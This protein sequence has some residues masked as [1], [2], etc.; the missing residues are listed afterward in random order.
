MAYQ[1]K[2]YKKF[3][4]TAATATLVASAVAPAAFAADFTDVTGNYKEAVDFVVSKGVNGTSA[5][6][7]GTSEAIKRVDAA[8][9]LASVL[10]LDIEKAPASG[11]TDVPERAV[12]HVNALKAAGITS[13]KTATTFDANANITR[14]ELAIWIQ[15]GFALKATSTSVAF[16]DVTDRYKEAVAALVDNKVTSGVSETAFGTNA[17]AKRGDFAIFLHRAA[18]T[19]PAKLAI[20]ASATGAK[21]LEVKFNTAV[22]TAK[23]TVTV[24]KGTSNVAISKVTFSEDKKSAVVEL[25]AKLTEGTY[26]VT[27]GDATAE[28]KA[29][30]EKVKTVEL[31][32]DKALTAADGKSVLVGYKVVNQYDENITS[33]NTAY[34]IVPYAT[35]GFAVT[36]DDVDASKGLVTIKKD[37]FKTGDTFNLTLIDNKSTISVSKTLT[38]ADK[39]VVSAVEVTGVYNA[40]GSA[41]N[42]DN[43]AED[44]YLTVVAKDQYG[45]VITDA[46]QL[47]SGLLVNV[48]GSSAA[49]K[50]GNAAA[51]LQNFT[52][53]EDKDKKKHT[54]IALDLKQSGDTVFTLVSLAN[55][56]PVQYKVSV[57][58]GVKLDT[59]SIGAPTGLVAG[60]DTVLLPVS[61]TDNKGNA[62]TDATKV[63]GKITPGGSG[64]SDAKWVTKD[65]ALYIELK[66]NTTTTQSSLVVTLQSQTNKF[67]TEVV[68]VRETAKPKY[69][70]GL[71]SDVATSIY[72]GEKLALEAKHF[73]IQDQYNRDMAST[74]ARFAGTEITAVDGNTG[75][76]SKLTLTGLTVNAGEVKGTETVT[77]GLKDVTG[78]STDV[79]FRVVDRSEFTTYEVA[80]IAT[81][82]AN[83]VQN[84][85]ED[86]A[87]TLKVSG[88]L[89][90]GTKV[91]IPAD[92]YNVVLSSETHVK[93]KDGVLDAKADAV[94][95]KVFEGSVNVVVTI[96]ATGQEI[97]KA[98]T[99]SEAAPSVEKVEF[100]KDSKVTTTL[101]L[102]A[103]TTTFSGASIIDGIVVTDTYGVVNPGLLGANKDQYRLTFTN[104]KEKT[105]T[106][107]DI[108]LNG[109]TGANLADLDSGDTFDATFVVGGKSVKLAVTVK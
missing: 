101:E 41:V 15:K 46:A 68:T 12:K 11:L 76:T 74:D 30:N 92:E 56:T 3:V 1:P 62:V 70:I 55:G 89:A 88:V 14:G 71:K 69:V 53:Y 109:T 13:G 26:T 99:V 87:R 2:S 8:V 43:K 81:I 63:T 100:K 103:G 98:V 85:T 47:E 102:A 97:V 82:Y 44:F 49:V 35:N 7:F 96:N 75:D 59:V 42:E 22:D 21:K 31:L 79:T 6:T 73:V 4:A 23:T 58:S 91:A 29:E 50:D 27:S 105:G 52:T 106:D 77:F 60:G 95:D 48:S 39:S 17:N 5:T 32:S 104:V 51:G 90:D 38:V 40:K 80:D 72:A 34:E 66:A 25:N 67:D 33:T 64:F 86:Y 16:T 9:M 36:K 18:S 54:A 61:I 10:G 107:L 65:G 94:L 108:N 28:V 93:Y 24:K 84:Y 78:S 37:S 45:T 19:V 57:D 83:D 20:T